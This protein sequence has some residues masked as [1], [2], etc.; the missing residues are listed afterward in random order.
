ATTD[1]PTRYRERPSRMPAQPRVDHAVRPALRQVP[2]RLGRSACRRPLRRASPARGARTN[3]RP[4][5]APKPRTCTPGRFDMARSHR[6]ASFRIPAPGR[7][8]APGAAFPP[9]GA[10]QTG[11]LAVTGRR[12]ERLPAGFGAPGVRTGGVKACDNLLRG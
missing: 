9:P 3:A 8:R 12:Q 11:A 4:D 1:A 2:P 5:A 7:A 6:V 10:R